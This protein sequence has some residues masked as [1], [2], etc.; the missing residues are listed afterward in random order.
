V[1]LWGAGSLW[2]GTKLPGE[3][4]GTPSLAMA[5]SAGTLEDA[6]HHVE[7]CAV[8]LQEV[9][10][11]LGYGQ[12]P[13]AHQQAGKNVIGEMRRRLQHAPL[14]A[15]G[16]YAP[17]FAGEGHKVVVRA[18]GSA[19]KVQE[20]LGHA[21]IQTTRGYDRHKTRPEDSPTYKLAYK[22]GNLLVIVLFLMPYSMYGDRIKPLIEII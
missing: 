7:H 12:H 16:A 14:V 2:V 1:R 8:T 15:R 13:L 6:Q 9:E 10:Q 21:S 19:A 5:G 4:P 3:H 22:T 17:A 20:R 18:V 11:A